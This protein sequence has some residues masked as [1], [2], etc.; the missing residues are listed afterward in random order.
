MTKRGFKKEFCKKGLVFLLASFASF[1]FGQSKKY[2]SPSQ[3]KGFDQLAAEQLEKI[4][5][6]PVF[7]ENGQ[8]VSVNENLFDNVE[9]FRDFA[10][11]TFCDGEVRDVFESKR[12]DVSRRLGKLEKIAIRDSD[13]LEDNYVL[14]VVGSRE[15]R[16]IDW[17]GP[18]SERL[19]ESDLV[20][21]DK[22]TVLSG[23]EATTDNYLGVLTD[24]K[25]RMDKDDKL[26]IIFPGDG[27]GYYKNL[28]WVPVK[29][30]G[31]TYVP[32]YVSEDEGL[33]EF[34]KFDK[35]C[36]ERDCFLRAFSSGGLYGKYVGLNEKRIYFNY[37]NGERV[38]YGVSFVAEN[39]STEKVGINRVFSYLSSDVDRDVRISDD[40][41][42]L[43]YYHLWTDTTGAFTNEVFDIKKNAG[44]AL[45]IDAKNFPD[46]AFAVRLDDGKQYLG[47]CLN[48]WESDYSKMNVNLIDKDGDGLLSGD[49][50][51]D[52]KDTGWVSLQER[53]YFVDGFLEDWEAFDIPLK[54]FRDYGV[55]VSLFVG[56]CF[57]GG[58][59]ENARGK[60]VSSFSMTDAYN[61]SGG[62]IFEE[63][64][65]N[66]LCYD[67]SGFLNA[68]LNMDGNLTF[69]EMVRYIW[70]NDP[71][72]GEDPILGYSVGLHHWGMQLNADEDRSPS[73]I[74]DGY[75]SADWVAADNVYLIGG[76][77]NNFVSH[78][79]APEWKVYDAYPN[80]FNLETKLKFSSD[81]AGRYGVNVYDVRGRLVRKLV[82]GHYGAGEHE[83]IWDG[84][85]DSGAGVGSGVYFL[86]LAGNDGRRE[87]RK[88]VVV[89]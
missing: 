33:V 24:Y 83:I 3:V 30:V 12:A 62:N 20:E 26:V 70:K 87:V 25:T 82:D 53:F 77:E 52:G 86:N 28:P 66:G 85:G 48:S 60:K 29:N 72:T 89:K 54:E 13:G 9:Y 35:D 39:D 36:I 73:Y 76:Q 61:I 78:S 56:H 31:F 65:T 1:G 43:F 57:G 11:V 63:N 75:D 74:R 88:V 23:A 4:K 68:D 81:R 45:S 19:I 47:A 84:R 2:F 58:T 21:V 50:N 67:S 49:F 27:A 5:Q 59:H 79:N 46:H 37:K 69:G 8:M 32:V 15:K 17:V 10:R 80:P 41:K 71:M 7:Y 38:A 16:F 6:E 55:Q 22:L 18:L 51:G 42:D 14:Y 64:L 44:L 34:R 40:E